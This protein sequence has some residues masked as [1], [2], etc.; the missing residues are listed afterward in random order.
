MKKIRGSSARDHAP[1]VY[2]IQ[3]GSGGPI[4]IGFTEA[5]LYRRLE[6]IQEENASVLRVRGVIHEE[7]P[8]ILEYAL[9]QMFAEYRM[10]GEWFLPSEAIKDFIAENAVKVEYTT[11]AEFAGRERLVCEMCHTQESVTADGKLCRN[12]LRKWIRS[13]TPGKTSRPKRKNATYYSSSGE[14]DP[15]FEN[16]V[17]NIED[18]CQD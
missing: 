16:A 15:S 2:F 4:K 18:G 14:Q 13:E 5:G 1:C 9:H 6:Q 11:C 17:R 7:N 10:H 3:Q 12:C 8:H